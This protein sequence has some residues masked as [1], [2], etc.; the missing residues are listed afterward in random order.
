MRLEVTREMAADRAYW[1]ESKA[2]RKMNSR[3]DVSL[4]SALA[5]VRTWRGRNHEAI[6]LSVIGGAVGILL[7]PISTAIYASTKH[8]GVVIPPLAW[9]G[10]IGASIF[11]GAGVG[12]WRALPAVR[13]SPTEA[14]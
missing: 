9:G 10:G 13:A 12:L 5:E 11:V 14:L 7:G 4:S 1:P 3:T 2:G 8:W 6:L